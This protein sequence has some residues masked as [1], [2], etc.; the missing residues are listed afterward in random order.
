MAANDLHVEKLLSKTST[1]HVYLCADKKTV[2]KEYLPEEKLKEKDPAECE[3]PGDE[4]FSCE[5]IL[6]RH[7]NVTESFATELA[8][9]SIP[10]LQVSPNIVKMTGHGENWIQTEYCSEGNLRTFLRNRGPHLPTLLCWDIAKAL[11]QGLAALHR[12]GIV[13]T[14]L[15]LENIFIH[16]DE[17]S[18]TYQ[19]KIGGLGNAYL[20]KNKKKGEE[21]PIFHNPTC[22]HYLNNTKAGDIYAVSIIL[23]AMKQKVYIT[24][25]LVWMKSKF[26]NSD[27][28]RIETDIP[29]SHL[30]Q[31]IEDNIDYIG[32]SNPVV[33]K[34]NK[35][36]ECEYIKLIE[37]LRSFYAISISNLQLIK[38]FERLK[39][40]MLLHTLHGMRRIGEGSYADVF[41]VEKPNEQRYVL[42]K[43][44]S[45]IELW[46]DKINKYEIIEAPDAQNS[47]ELEL[48]VFK[49]ADIMNSSNFVRLL[50]SGFDEIDKRFWMK[51][52]CCS[53]K[54]LYS[55]MC[56]QKNLIPYEQQFLILHN[57][58]SGLEILHKYGIHRD[59]SLVN[60]LIHIDPKNPF[61]LAKLSDFG[62][63]RVFGSD[64][65]ISK[66][67][68]DIHG[69]YLFF[70]KTTTAIDIFA[71]GVIILAMATKE[72]L[73]LAVEIKKEASQL[74]TITYN[75]RTTRIIKGYYDYIEEDNPSVI[76]EESPARSLSI[77]CRKPAN[78]RLT[79]T[80]ARED[81]EDSSVHFFKSKESHEKLIHQKFILPVLEKVFHFLSNCE[82]R[83]VSILEE[84]QEIC[85]DNNKNYTNKFHDIYN[86][87]DNYVD[88]PLIRCRGFFRSEKDK[89]TRALMKPF[90][91]VFIAL[92]QNRTIE[93]LRDFEK[94]FETFK[95]RWE[96][97]AEQAEKDSL[98]EQP[99]SS[100]HI[101]LV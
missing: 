44:K 99:S 37:L 30:V 67:Y 65:L 55:F 19:V 8:I 58:L 27:L 46:N 97:A 12:N 36:V 91:V 87:I 2:R 100:S 73:K 71:V 76:L 60:I 17:V 48:S 10:E 72:K 14:H 20:L 39:E 53:E 16:Y 29:R 77:R 69:M 61:S 70:E 82:V 47:Y 80:M 52:E 49:I 32:I 54:D 33:N 88:D 92:Y 93:T 13:H 26:P 24:D 81:L 51:L 18:K 40:S 90:F 35:T 85:K 66:D 78:I 38:E 41:I 3:L 21:A 11:L 83:S 23:L 68:F 1:N 25:R 42:K 86:L 56:S 34:V 101:M 75:N 5:I 59:L 22:P 50:D 94:T 79:A 98:Y 89:K 15:T 4:G 64:N 9:L 95:Q 45:H 6:E 7:K 31:K 43:F 28:L 74:H 62:I 63:A 84:I 57:I 96:A